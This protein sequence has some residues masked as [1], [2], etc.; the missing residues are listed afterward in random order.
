MLSVPH[1]IVIFLVALVVFGPEKLPELARNVGKFMAEFRRMSNEF[2]GT[3]EG[4]MRD[5][6]RETQ[7]RRANATPPATAPNV[8]PPV[9]DMIHGGSS[10]N[11]ES[12]AAATGLPMPTPAQGIVPS[13]DPRIPPPPPSEPAANSSSETAANETPAAAPAEEHAYTPE[14][15]TDGQ[16]HTN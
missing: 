4:H 15:V 6:E 2:K 7:E 9:D 1:L 16:S 8:T 3:F 5:L 10:P 12:A 14:P 13:A 11:G